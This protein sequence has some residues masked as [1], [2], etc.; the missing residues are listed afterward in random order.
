MAAEEIDL[1]CSQE[2]DNEVHPRKRKDVVHV[3]DTSPTPKKLRQE[4]LPPSASQSDDTN[5]SS[6]EWDKI[7][8]RLQRLEEVQVSNKVLHKEQYVT[9]REFNELAGRL[10][11]VEE[12][13]QNMEQVLGNVRAAFL[14]EDPSKKSINRNS[15]HS[16]L[17]SPPLNNIQ[18]NDE[19]SRSLQPSSNGQA[20]TTPSNESNVKSTHALS[21][22]TAKPQNSKQCTNGLNVQPTIMNR[23]ISSTSASTPNTPIPTN[24]SGSSGSL[25]SQKQHQKLS[26]A[27][28]S[29]ICSPQ[30]NSSNSSRVQNTSIEIVQVARKVASQ[31]M[32]TPMQRR[33]DHLPLPSAAS[34]ILSS[35]PQ[36]KAG[37]RPPHISNNNLNKQTNNSTVH[38]RHSAPSTSSSTH[39]PISVNHQPGSSLSSSLRASGELTTKQVNSV[40]QKMTSNYLLSELPPEFITQIRIKREVESEDTS[41]VEEVGTPNHI[42]VGENCVVYIA[43]TGRKIRKHLHYVAISGY[44]YEGQNGKVMPQ[45]PPFFTDLNMENIQDL[46]HKEYLKTEALVMA[47]L[48]A[49]QAIRHSARNCLKVTIVASKSGRKLISNMKNLCIGERFLETYPNVSKCRCEKLACDH[50]DRWTTHSPFARMY[51]LHKL[52]I[53]AEGIN[54]EWCDQDEQQCQALLDLKSTMDARLAQ[55]INQWRGKT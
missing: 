44:T 8:R 14:F 15:L 32:Q 42:R 40:P 26:V 54:V 1:T 11:Q 36:R 23:T 17:Y 30:T 55:A 24:V 27:S 37:E 13:V 52:F 5:I 51:D 45:I 2:E 31:D 16:T 39:V 49:I 43:G 35:T 9:R 47:A 34:N 4:P 20:I 22:N 50:P 19:E 12:R 46:K 25:V 21:L 10:I 41:V 28:S 33:S 18:S 3:I 53:A 38:H 48:K 6:R 29:T 7:H